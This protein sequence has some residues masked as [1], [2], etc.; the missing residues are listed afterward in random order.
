[1]NATS[2]ALAFLVSVALQS[3]DG[4]FLESAAVSV[5]AVASLDYFF[6]EPRF[7]FEVAS[8]VDTIGLACLLIASLIV[9]QLQSRARAK[10]AESKL[11]RENMTRLYN[12][13]Q[14]LLGLEPGVTGS[15]RL[16]P[17]LAEFDLRA[18]CVF[19][20]TTLE[21]YTTGT[22]RHA[23]EAKT[24][25]AYIAGW[26]ADEPELEIAVRCLWMRGTIAGAI[27][28]EGLRDPALIAPSLAALATAD[29]ERSRASRQATNAAMH[30]DAEML[31]SAILDAL[32][33]EIKTPL[34]AILTAAGGI[35]ATGAME[36][37]QA[38]LAELIESEASRLGRLTSRL[39]RTARLDT[40]E[41]KPR[42]ERVTA[43]ELAEKAAR[44]YTNL[45]RDRRF[46]F[47]AFGHA[48]EIRADP[49]LIHLAL[50]QLLE[51]ACRYSQP[52]ANVL[53]EVSS[54]GSLAAITVMNDGAPIPASEHNR[55]FDR[56]YRGTDA[57]RTAP[58]S[59]LGLY[60]ARK[61]AVAH[62]GDIALVEAGPHAVAFRLSLPI[63]AS[64]ASGDE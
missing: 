40:E 16:K 34:A 5:L 56:F 50:S 64:E 2:T 7:S 8:P 52:D 60:V 61:I 30:A 19:D 48:G 58:G 13:S 18:V 15:A 22:P 63:A 29:L 51:N 32:A 14:Q 3:L 23:L 54:A 44:R 26:G 11:Q 55:I 53:V 24:R 4:S 57:R 36:P 47:R 21:C 1:L 9:T 20:A 28:F 33:H 12:V 41:I 35:R 6:T 25:D 49:D 17:I 37:Q 27:G 42:L 62:G 10:A 45:W 39:L 59:G 46:S 38:E 31:R 43:A